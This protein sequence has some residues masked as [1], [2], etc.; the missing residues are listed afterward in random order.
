MVVN[1]TKEVD[2]IIKELEQ[3]YFGFY[4]KLK[5]L[6][7]TVLSQYTIIL[8]ELQTRLSIYQRVDDREFGDHSVIDD[9]AKTLARVTGGLKNI[10]PKFQDELA[11]EIY[12]NLQELNSVL[13]KKQEKKHGEVKKV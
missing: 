6:L 2:N 9:T 3:G 11:E 4:I 12:I 1:E 10:L 8:D 7:K 5:D 13:K